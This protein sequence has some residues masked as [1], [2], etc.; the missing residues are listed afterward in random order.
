MSVTFHV[1][2]SHLEFYLLYA[3]ARSVEF[4]EMLNV[5]GQF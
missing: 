2:E 4:S 1:D 3:W 5:S